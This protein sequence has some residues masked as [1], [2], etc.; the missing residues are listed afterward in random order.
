LDIILYL[1]ATG[2][3]WWRDSREESPC[4]K[5]DRTPSNRWPE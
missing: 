5:W 2:S 1:G 3:C 4:Y